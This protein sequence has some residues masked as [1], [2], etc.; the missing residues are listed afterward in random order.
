MQAVPNMTA[1]TLYLASAS[2]RRREILDQL[3]IAYGLHPQDIDESRMLNE[4]AE[5]YVCRLAKTKAENAL[6]LV[7][8]QSNSACLGADTKVVCDG[9]IFE[10]PEDE[11]DAHRILQA[12]S[13]RTHLVLTAVALARTGS[14]E[15]LLSS[16]EVTF[17]ALTEAEIKNYWQTGEPADKAGAYGIQGLGAIFVKEIKGS[18]SGIMGLPVFETISLLAKIDITAEKILEQYT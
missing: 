1:V 13:G 9:E 5:D 12:L 17:K 4:D 6:S 18:Y 3:G 10:K 11:S 14:T 2:P 16:S 8:E 7:D 15:V